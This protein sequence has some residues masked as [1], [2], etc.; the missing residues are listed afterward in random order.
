MPELIGEG[1]KRGSM[2]GRRRDVSHVIR[3][4]SKTIGGN[5]NPSLSCLCEVTTS[6]RGDGGE[7]CLT[8]PMRTLHVQ[9][10]PDS[11]VSV[12]GLHATIESRTPN[13]MC[14]TVDVSVG[15]FVT[16][17]RAYPLSLI[18]SF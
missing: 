9:T 6:K 8:Q 10:V 17:T 13:G 4:L 15:R 16:R 12:N 11:L 5:W 3:E 2:R 18:N 7:A 1:P 14:P